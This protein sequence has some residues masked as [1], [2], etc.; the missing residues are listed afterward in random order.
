MI[1]EVEIKNFNSN[2]YNDQ[3]HNNRNLKSYMS[4]SKKS[5]SREF[6]LFFPLYSIHTNLN[7]KSQANK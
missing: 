2:N 4:L 7:K 6:N 3:N 1:F 5:N